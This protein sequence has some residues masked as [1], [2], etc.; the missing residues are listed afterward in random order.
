MPFVSAGD[1]LF[2][3]DKLL[4]AGWDPGDWSTAIYEV[5]PGDPSRSKLYMSSPPFFG[6]MS[7]P[8]TCGKSRYFGLLP[9]ENHTVLTELDLTNKTVVGDIDSIPGKIM[10]AASTTET[11]IDN[12][13]TIAGAAKINADNC[14]NANGSITITASSPN[15]PITY[16]LLNTGIRQSSGKFSDLRGGLYRFRVTDGAGC[17]KDTSITL[18]ENIPVDGCKDIFIPNAFTPNNDGKNDIFKVF[19]PAMFSDISIQVFG[20]WGNVVYVSKGNAIYWDGSFKGAQQP[21]GVYIYNLA[22][23][24]Q[25]GERKSM[26]GTLALIR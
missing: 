20:R 26:K 21:A 8:V 14:A 22:Y 10:D 1:M 23:T 12:N 7:L 9:T 16:T 17:S 2:F 6:L 15:I 18:A 11:G 25:D 3:N 5:D 24:G 19:I 4:L 13:I